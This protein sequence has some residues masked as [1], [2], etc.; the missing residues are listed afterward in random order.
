MGEIA[1][2]QVANAMVA[3]RW[4][5][6]MG[7]RTVRIGEGRARGVVIYVAVGG[8]RARDGWGRRRSRRKDV[9]DD[10]YDRFNSKTELN[11][12]TGSVC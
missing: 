3:G 8:S 2:A 10:F 5:L 1:M 11:Q 4:H 12:R 9:S 6:S 7:W